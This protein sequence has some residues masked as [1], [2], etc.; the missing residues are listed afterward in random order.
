MKI[1]KCKNC[2]SDNMYLVYT[3]KNNGYQVRCSECDS[4]QKYASHSDLTDNDKKYADI[5]E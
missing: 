1:I 3:P 5:K 4:F 2:N